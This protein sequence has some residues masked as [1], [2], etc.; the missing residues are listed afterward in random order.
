MSCIRALW[1]DQS[2]VLVSQIFR[3]LTSG[4]SGAFR[5]LSRLQASLWHI[6]CLICI[7]VVQYD[8]VPDLK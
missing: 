8:H 3:C 7:W 4:W 6:A 1:S 2:I 5:S